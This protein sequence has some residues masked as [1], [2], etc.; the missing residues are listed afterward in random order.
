MSAMPSLFLASTA[1]TIV[2]PV[3]SSS[4]GLSLSS[5]ALQILAGKDNILSSTTFNNPVEYIENYG[6]LA[7]K[8]AGAVYLTS[9]LVLAINKN[10]I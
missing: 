7:T 10:N 8:A 3:I 1:M 2:E 5:L 6:I 4:L 9:L